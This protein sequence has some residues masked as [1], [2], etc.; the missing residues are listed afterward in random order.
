LTW[1][2]TLVVA[3]AIYPVTKLIDLLIAFITEKREFKKRR[4]E[5][6]LSR[7]RNAKE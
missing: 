4:R 1:W 7:N 6:A 5:L 2:Q 3:L